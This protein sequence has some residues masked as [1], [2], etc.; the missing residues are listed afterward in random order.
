M[1]LLGR[2]H[3]EVAHKVIST[4]SAVVLVAAESIDI[5][6]LDGRLPDLGGGAEAE[7]LAGLPTSARSVVVH[8][9]KAE[10]T[11]PGSVD[12]SKPGWE[13]RLLLAAGVRGE[14][15]PIRL[16][17]VDDHEMIRRGLRE[18]VQEIPELEVVGDADRASIALAG[19]EKTPPDV[20]LLDVRLP[21]MGGVEL[22]REIRSRFPEVRCLMFTAYSYDETMVDA[23]MAGA[24]GYLLKQTA[25]E[26][27]LDS[28]RI[29]AE[30]GTLIDPVMAEN[31]RVYLGATGPRGEPL[32]PQ[33][34]RVLDLIVEGLSNREI[35]ARLGLAEKTVKNYVSAVL[36]KLGVHSRTQ[37]ALYRL[38]RRSE[39]EDSEP[40]A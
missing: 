11:T 3:V 32:S 19:I 5:A 30:G 15:D 36:E 35:G 25:G 20:A 8:F 31:I 28:I 9:G 34:Q 6:I 18:F 2:H 39:P 13:R 26:D 22:C 21:D 24:S 38:R 7:V 33:Q 29:V 37:A 23:I 1:D 14:N 4:A 16:F 40:D 17:V 10:E 12:A 27:L